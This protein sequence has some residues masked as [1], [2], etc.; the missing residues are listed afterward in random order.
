MDIPHVQPRAPNPGT[1]EP[2]NP[3][4]HEPIRTTDPGPPLYRL[5]PAD[6]KDR[7]HKAIAA[8]MRGVPEEIVERQLSHFAKA[9]P[10]Y[11]KGVR[12][13]LNLVAA[14]EDGLPAR[15]G[16]QRCGRAG[17]PVLPSGRAGMPVLPLRRAGMPVLPLR[18]AGMPVFR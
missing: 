5:L 6:E 7:L 11:A 16:G 8:A 12:K 17:M 15:R 2:R 18:R 4:T 3:G 1:T 14:G 9:D 10:A 13:A